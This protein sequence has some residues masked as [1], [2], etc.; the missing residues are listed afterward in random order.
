MQDKKSFY[1]KKKSLKFPH[2]SKFAAQVK[3]FVQFA[4]FLLSEK[5]SVRFL[6]PQIRVILFWVFQI[7]IVDTAAVRLCM[8]FC[9]RI[10]FLEKVTL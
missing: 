4:F 8:C 7:K 9:I 5:L 6:A 2:T 10:C 1:K 3:K